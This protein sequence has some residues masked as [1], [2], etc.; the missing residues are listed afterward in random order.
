MSRNRPKG[1]GPNTVI[2]HPIY[3]V[4][5]DC[6]YFGENY[7]CNYTG[8]RC[9]IKWARLHCKNYE[10]L[11]PIKIKKMLPV[12]NITKEKNEPKNKKIEKFVYIS[13]N[14]IVMR[15]PEGAAKTILAKEPQKEKPKPII[16]LN[17]NNKNIG[18]Y[19]VD[20]KRGIGK[21]T[22][23]DEDFYNVKFIDLD[24]VAKIKFSKG[25]ITK[26]YDTYYDAKEI[27][28]YDFDELDIK[29]ND[30][31]EIN[32]KQY[33]IKSITTYNIVLSDGTLIPIRNT[34]FNL[35]NKVNRIN[36]FKK[37]K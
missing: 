21:I 10:G 23:V 3:E 26:I 8:G 15:V 6:K 20:N 29:I 25:K 1:N 32:N 13:K 24:P 2:D 9:D 11:K 34:K 19:I 16:T 4:E 5:F 22:R 12:Q 30:Y 14:G 27:I 28:G 18:K 37:I 31:F 17:E 7:S 33:K 36:V 35:V